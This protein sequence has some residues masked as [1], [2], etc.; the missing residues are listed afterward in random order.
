M[1]NLQQIQ[2][3]QNANDDNEDN[4]KVSKM[5]SMCL[6][7]TMNK[8]ISKIWSSYCYVFVCT[9]FLEMFCSVTCQV[10]FFVRYKISSYMIRVLL[11]LCYACLIVFYCRVKSWNEEII[12]QTSIHD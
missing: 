10:I 6:M 9:I 12:L 2:H 3:R 8:M 4:K 1:L 11:D 7:A 5:M